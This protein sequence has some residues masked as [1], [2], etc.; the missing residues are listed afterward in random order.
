MKTIIS[1]YHFQTLHQTL[2]QTW[3]Q[4]NLCLQQIKPPPSHPKE[5]TTFYKQETFKISA[6]KDI[7]DAAVPLYQEELDANGYQHT[8]EFDPL[9]TNNKDKLGLRC[10]KLRLSLNLSGFY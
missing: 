1:N 2:H 7:F 4:A 10:A 6:N 5:Y 8:L 3:G 9:A